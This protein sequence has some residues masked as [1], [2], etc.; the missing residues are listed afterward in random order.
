MKAALE[1]YHHTNGKS[2]ADVMASK[3]YQNCGK[4]MKIILECKRS[5]A[6]EGYDN[7]LAKDLCVRLDSHLQKKN[8]EE[9][10]KLLANMS[11]PQF[12]SVNEAYMQTHKKKNV[13]QALNVFSGDFY[14]LLVAR[15]TSK[16]HYLCSHLFDDKESTSR[17]LGCLTRAECKTLRDCFDV[18]KDVYGNNRTLETVLRAEIKKESYLRACLNLVS[19]DTTNFPIGTDRELREDEVLVENVV[20]GIEQAA[21]EAYDAERM[22]ELGA[23]KAA[24]LGVEVDMSKPKVTLHKGKEQTAACI[25]ELDDLI[26]ELKQQVRETEEEV[27]HKAELSFAVAAHLRQAEEWTALYETYASQLNSHIKRIDEGEQLDSNDSSRHSLLGVPVIG[28]IIQLGDKVKPPKNPF[29]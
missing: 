23:E 26:Q 14:Q 3:L 4:L 21:R 15:C 9:V 10:I 16:Y 13:Y 24:E 5:E 20:K 2:F 17:I 27:T 29:G 11:I 22:R 12:N 1:Y 7:A 6:E 19:T 28:K 8:A 18:N 25:A